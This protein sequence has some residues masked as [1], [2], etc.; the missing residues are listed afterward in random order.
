VWNGDYVALFL[1]S[2]FITLAVILVIVS[3]QNASVRL[4]SV[5][6][7]GINTFTIYITGEHMDSILMYECAVRD[8]SDDHTADKCAIDG[9]MGRS[10]MCIHHVYT[11][12][13]AGIVVHLLLLCVII[14]VHG[15]LWCKCDVD[16]CV[17]INQSNAIGGC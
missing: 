7:A 13:V 10:I 16:T 15:E 6:G 4:M 5:S 12:A 17:I 11:T 1:L 2:V 9:C 8:S 14:V 3:V